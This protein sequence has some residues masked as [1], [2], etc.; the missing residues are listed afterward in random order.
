MIMRG[1][2]WS[3]FSKLFLLPRASMESNVGAQVRFVV[4]TTLKIAVTFPYTCNFAI[5]GP[6]IVG[7]CVHGTV[8][9]MRKTAWMEGS[10]G[11]DREFLG[12][13]LC[14]VYICSIDESVAA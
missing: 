5:H 3:R 11:L 9:R 12:H 8:H 7:I 6:L 10:Q 1:C 4:I 13:G 2:M 14:S